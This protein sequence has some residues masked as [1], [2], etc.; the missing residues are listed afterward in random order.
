MKKKIIVAIVILTVF[1]AAAISA[2]ILFISGDDAPP[3]ELNAYIVVKVGETVINGTDG[4]YEIPYPFAGAVTLDLYFKGGGE[5][6]VRVVCGISPYTGKDIDYSEPE[7]SSALIW[8]D[9]KKPAGD[10]YY[11]REFHD[12]DFIYFKWPQAFIADPVPL[13]L[14]SDFKLRGIDDEADSKITKLTLTVKAE[15]A[16]DRNA[17]LSSWKDYSGNKLERFPWEQ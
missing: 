5:G 16:P 6:Y 10:I 14:F 17:A 1:A 3:A 13:R 2:T 12:K 9:Q 7:F 11:R 15:A 8:S 4:V